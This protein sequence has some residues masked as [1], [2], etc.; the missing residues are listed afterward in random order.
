M[1]AVK[2][3]RAFAAYVKSVAND[4]GYDRYFDGG[5]KWNPWVCYPVA[6]WTIVKQLKTLTKCKIYGHDMVDNSYAGPDTGCVDL[7]CTR[8]GWDHTQILY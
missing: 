3:V 2:F 4:V 5:K 8:C 7:A 6:L 1:R